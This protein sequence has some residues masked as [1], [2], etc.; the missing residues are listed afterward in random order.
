MDSF[1]GFFGHYSSGKLIMIYFD[2]SVHTYML[3]DSFIF[4]VI[5]R[6]SGNDKEKTFIRLSLVL[7]KGMKQLT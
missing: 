1:K 5:M 4:V 3:H 2:H 6:G 7:N